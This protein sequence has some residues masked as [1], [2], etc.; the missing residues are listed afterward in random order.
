MISGLFFLETTMERLLTKLAGLIL[1]VLFSCPLWAQEVPAA[2]KGIPQN[3]MYHK[4]TLIDV[5]RSVWKDIP[6]PSAVA[7]LIEQET[8]P[9]ITSKRCWSRFAKL[10]TPH[11]AGYG[12]GQF[13]ITKKFNAFE[14]VRTL[15]P[16]LKDWQPENYSDSRLQLIAVHVKLK[17]NFKVFKTAA[18]DEERFSFA[19]AAY[20]GGV[21]GILADQRVCRNTKDC[22]SSKWWGNVEHTSLKTKMV[23][24]GF[25]KSAFQINREYPYNI[26]KVRRMKYEPYI[27]R[28]IIGR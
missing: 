17:Q 3:F 27:N 24:N 4:D 21:G 5:M 20:N 22:D 14:E 25:K 9:S 19:L 28:E 8:C 6:Y 23:F 7:G 1:L 11:E 12:L 18:D 16:E 26:M 10:E 15:H 2:P 13:T